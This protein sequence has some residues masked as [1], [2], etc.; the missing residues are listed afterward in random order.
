MKNRLKVLSVMAILLCLCLLTSCGK[1]GDE[2]AATAVVEEEGIAEA[3]DLGGVEFNYL[4]AGNVAANDFGFDEESSMPLDN[5]QYKRKALVQQEYNV[6]INSTR[7]AAYSSGG[8]PG[9]MKISTA[10]NAGDCA[11]DLALI[12]GYD[13]SV[14]AYS[15]M[16]YD[17]AS[18]PGIHLEKSYW[19]QNANQSLSVNGVLFFT[20]GDITISDNNASFVIMYNK[21]LGGDYGI[22][23]PYDLVYDGQWTI[24]RFAQL[25]KTVTED[26]NQDGAMDDNDRYGL[27]VWDDSIVGIVNAAG[28]RCCTIDED[29]KI[30]LTFY[31]ERTLAALEK[32]ASIAYDT[33]YAC[34]YQRLGSGS[35]F[36]KKL[37][38][39]DQ[40]LFWTTYMGIVPSFR[41]MESD[42]GLLP[43]PKMDETQDAYYTTIAPYNS[44]FICVPLVQND[45][46][47]TGI[48]TE[49]LA[50]YGKEIVTPA[51]YDVSLK[52]QT[53]RDEQSSDM[54]DIIFDSY[55]F[56]I[57][58]YYQIG[59]YNKQ[60]IYALRAFDRNFASMYDSYKNP[61]NALLS[62]INEYYAEAVAEWID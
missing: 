18:V 52:G 38:S 21:K 49:A 62:V 35:Q 11:Y 31:S 25:C 16:L 4:T 53:A 6:T 58:Y 60:L 24:D 22:D 30:E 54:L 26:L 7:E 13:V 17:L 29:G 39:G 14:L 2:T 5:A 23:S 3:V 1:D 50:Y 51:Y 40:G 8:G 27:L 12:A 10:V 55:V 61:A 46:E 43:Y 32:Y 34:T 44:Q 45:V 56:D 48:L 42:F 9:F 15:G 19:D 57:G 59:P 20:T 28:E 33:Q 37:W 47:R 36:E 41:E